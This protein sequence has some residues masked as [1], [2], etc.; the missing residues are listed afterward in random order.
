MIVVEGNAESEWMPRRVQTSLLR[1]IDAGTAASLAPRVPGADMRD[2][3]AALRQ[4]IL[5]GAVEG[6][7]GGLRLTDNGRRQ[8]AAE[9]SA[10][11]V[12]AAEGGY[13]AGGRDVDG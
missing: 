4:L 7:A 8:L 6:Q 13:G 1:E 9:E 10:G 2:V 5:E 12:A 11:R 3:E